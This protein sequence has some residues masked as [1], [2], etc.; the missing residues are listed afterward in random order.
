MSRFINDQASEEDVRTSREELFSE[1]ELSDVLSFPH[2]D[3]YGK[4]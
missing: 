2:V 1:E 4:A 3:K